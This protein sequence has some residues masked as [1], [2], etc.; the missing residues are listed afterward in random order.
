VAFPRRKKRPVRFLVTALLLIVAYFLLFPYPLGRELVAVPRWA[1]AVPAAADPSAAPASASAD[2]SSAVVPFRLGSRFG[3]VRPD[4]T[5]TYAGTVLYRVALSSAGFVNFAR[6]GSDWIIQD[7][8][9]RHL[10]SLSGSGYP[11]LSPD[12]LRV[13]TVKTDLSGIVERDRGGE[14]LWDRDFPTIMTSVSVQGDLLLVGLLDGTLHLLNRQGSPV[15]EFAPGGSRIPVVAGCALSPDGSLLAAVTGID[16]Q[17]LSVIGRQGDGFSPL[18]KTALPSAFRREVR[19]GFSPDSRIL[20]LE[21]RDGVG[22]AAP[23]SGGVRWI[24]LQG[25]LAGAAFP[26]LGKTSALASVDGSR[27]RLVIEP[28]FGTLVCREEFPAHVLSVGMI[29]GQL[30]LGVDGQLLRIDVEA[31]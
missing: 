27:G 16:P 29:Q 11:L 19:I 13:F 2:T 26:G 1:V 18:A 6:L 28:S 3:F 31:M 25:A 12:G 21:G 4:G 5:I 17:F 24:A 22:V 9:G 30:L 20:F 15:F 8:G 23:A 14:T 7:P 10:F